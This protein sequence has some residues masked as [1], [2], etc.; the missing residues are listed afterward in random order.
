MGGR[1]ATRMLCSGGGA[2]LLHSLFTLVGVALAEQEVGD[3]EGRRSGSEDFDFS[4]LAVETE[5]PVV[6]LLHT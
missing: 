6:C 3:E 2:L 4:L 5:T 1:C